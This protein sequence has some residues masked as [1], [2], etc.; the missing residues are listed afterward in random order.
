MEPKGTELEQA[1]QAAM[2]RI[3]DEVMQAYAAALKNAYQDNKIDLSILNKELDKARKAITPLAH[4]YLREEIVKST[5]VVFNEKSFN[6]PLKELAEITTATPNAL[7]HTDNESGLATWIEGSEVTSHDRGEGKE[8]LASRHI[9]T[10]AYDEKTGVVSPHPHPR[11]Q[12]R[13]PAIDAKNPK[14]S[15]EWHVDDVQNKI[16][17][18]AERYDLG[19]EDRRPNKAFIYNLYTSLYH[20]MDDY[21]NENMQTQGARQIIEGAHRYNASQLED[22]KIL[23]TDA[24]PLCFV[25]NIPINGFGSALGYGPFQ[26][27]LVEEASLMSEIALLHTLY[28]T[29]TPSQQKAIDEVLEQYKTYLTNPQ[30]ESAFCASTEGKNAI[31]MIQAIKKEWKSSPIAPQEDVVANA[32]AC[33]RNLVAHDM[34]FDKEFAKLTQSLSVF[35]EETS[36]GGCKS[37]NEH[38]QLINSRVS[39]LDALI[40]KKPPL[41]LDQTRLTNALQAFASSTP[42]SNPRELAKELKLSL[43]LALNKAGLQTALTLV[44][45]VDQGASAK[46]QVASGIGSFYNGNKFEEPTLSHLHQSKSSHMQAHKGLDKEM[47]LACTE[48][49]DKKVSA[50][51]VISQTLAAKAV[52]NTEEQQHL[53][54][55]VGRYIEDKDVPNHQ[56][57]G[58]RLG[59]SPAQLSEA[60]KELYKGIEQY[61]KAHLQK[62]AEYCKAHGLPIAQVDNPNFFREQFIKYS[63]SRDF[64]PYAIPDSGDPRKNNPEQATKT[65]SEFFGEDGAELY[66][67]ALKEERYS[68]EYMDAVFCTST[69]H[70][71]GEKWA[72]R[73]VIIVAGP[74]ASGKSTAAHAAVQRANSYL[75]KVTTSGAPPGNDVVAIDGGVFREISQMRKLAI[76]VANQ[77]GY[78][79]ISDLHDQSSILGKGK[80][81]IQKAVYATPSL[82]V[83]IPETFS[84]PLKVKPILK[85]IDNLPNTQTIFTRVDGTEP[86]T[87]R[88]VVGYLGPRRA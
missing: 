59:S 9:I 20:L 24:P 49:T 87:F 7:L 42:K 13:I 48:K 22:A 4:Q 71:E 19:E 6:Q 64:T 78:T 1:R 56:F 80:N 21:F 68:K 23:G 38:A 10:H 33:L 63:S 25:Q 11:T 67:L 52:V 77:Q 12:I 65:L 46:A 51:P 5:K 85:K 31:R 66:Q 75:P 53:L 16:S 84:N 55:Q 8:H 47:T 39:V 50:K 36:I 15:E 44:S 30:R 82:G 18:L 35:I 83:V 79:G 45:L 54:Q 76:R 86:T 17:H 43:D 74:S 88:R 62:I 29:S 28:K 26:R 32:A 34:H 72:Q 73:P 58:E 41:T 81:C 2:R 60:Q 61:R 3:N 40:L 57:V 70:Y 37:A 27:E 69:K 14:E